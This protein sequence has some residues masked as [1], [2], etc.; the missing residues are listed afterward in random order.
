ML[1]AL[2]WNL[3]ANMILHQ[4]VGHVNR[5]K[6]PSSGSVL[7]LDSSETFEPSQSSHVHNEVHGGDLGPSS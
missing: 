3:C 2:S 5:S 6:L 7:V 4:H 1:D